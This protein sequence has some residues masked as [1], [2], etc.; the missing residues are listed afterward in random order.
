MPAPSASPRARWAAALGIALAIVLLLALWP[1]PRPTAEQAAR[2]FLDC[3]AAFDS[4]C[5]YD[6]T[7]EAERTALGLDRQKMDAFVRE[8]V[9]PRLALAER[10]PAEASFANETGDCFVTQVVRLRTGRETTMNAYA[11]TFDEGP[12][13]PHVVATIWMTLAGWED[14][15]LPRPDSPAAKIEAQLSQARRDRGVLERLGIPGVYLGPDQGLHPWDEWIAKCEA[16]LE[17]VRR[18]ER[19]G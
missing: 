3:F 14:A 12:R 13:S 17:I 4:G 8:Y 2:R 5:L 16:R 18:K 11:A 10:S 15:A 9:R 6:L 1:K 19:G 7:S